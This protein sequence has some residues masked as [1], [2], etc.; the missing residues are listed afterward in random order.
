[1]AQSYPSWIS[2]R[3]SPIPNGEAW[4]PAF[5]GAELRPW[6]QVKIERV[7]ISSSETPVPSQ[8]LPFQKPKAVQPF[9]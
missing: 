2:Q 8:D 3:L 1:M 7:L 5:T 9:L 4:G 6:Q